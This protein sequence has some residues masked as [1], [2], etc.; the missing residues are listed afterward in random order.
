MFKRVKIFESEISSIILASFVIALVVTLLESIQSFA[1]ITLLI[2]IIISINI[3]GKKITA[4]YYDTEIKVQLWELKRYWFRA[5]DKFQHPFPIWIILPII[6]TTLTMG[7]VNWMACLTFQVKKP[8]HKVARR[9]DKTDY[10]FSEVTEFQTGVI[11]LGGFIANLIAIF[12]SIKIGIPEFI[13]LSALYMFYNI[14]PISDLDGTKIFFANKLLWI[15]SGV[16]IL[17]ITILSLIS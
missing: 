10:S 5:H 13:K 9:H 3:F 15:V 1:Y 6:L 16:I 14:F 4:Y 12:I 7:L 8:I 17:S 2:L 11:A